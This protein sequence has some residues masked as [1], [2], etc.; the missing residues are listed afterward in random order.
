MTAYTALKLIR[1]QSKSKRP[2]VR[3]LDVKKKKKKPYRSVERE[4]GMKD[5]IDN[6]LQHTGRNIL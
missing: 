6:I 1:A 2:V 4:P 5:R 3:K